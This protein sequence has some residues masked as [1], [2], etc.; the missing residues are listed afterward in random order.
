[1]K[2]FPLQETPLLSKTEMMITRLESMMQSSPHK[3]PARTPSTKTT[4]RKEYVQVAEINTNT[5]YKT[6]LPKG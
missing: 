6:R 3:L 5:D 4:R 2:N 1:M